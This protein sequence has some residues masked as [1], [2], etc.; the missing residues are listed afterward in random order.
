MV[1]RKDDSR[2]GYARALGLTQGS[3]MYDGAQKVLSE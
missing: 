3:G 1:P 2:G